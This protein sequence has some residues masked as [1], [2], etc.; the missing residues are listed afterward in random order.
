MI[1][2]LI[3]VFNSFSCENIKL[4]LYYEQ[5]NDHRNDKNTFYYT[6]YAKTILTLS[7]IM[8]QNDQTYF[9]NLAIKT[10]QDF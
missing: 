6:D 1:G 7:C 2:L 8:L 10:P 3:V 5:S 4:T 9:K